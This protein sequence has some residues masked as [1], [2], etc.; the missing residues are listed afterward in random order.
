MKKCIVFL[1]LLVFFG[2]EL[3]VDVDVPFEQSSLTL[4]TYFTPDSVWSAYVTSNRHILEDGPFQPVNNARI[5]VY[6]EGTPIDTLVKTDDGLY[7]SDTGK[8]T[9]GKNY[10]LTADAPGYG[11]ISAESAL[12]LPV[13]M[14][15]ATFSEIKSEHN[16]DFRIKIRIK[17]PVEKNYYQVICEREHEYYDFVTET[18]KTIRDRM[19]LRSEDPIVQSDN[20]E[21]SNVVIFDDVLFNGKEIDFTFDATLYTGAGLAS[22]TLILRTLSE[23]YYKYV[24]T[25][26]LQRNTSGDPFAQPVNVHN[27]IQNGFGIFAGYSTNTYTESK[28]RPI[29][30]GIDPPAAKPG[31]HIIITGENFMTNPENFI[32]VY[33]KGNPHVEYATVVESSNDQL[34]VIVPANA[35]TGKIAVESGRIVIS[36]TDFQ[37]ID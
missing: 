34:E 27:N 28:P 13:Q 7:Q 30:S 17:D 37:V 25:S 8:P 9:A 4:N 22:T 12:P 23:D 5:I 26:S 14:V 31:D 3:V 10:N 11:S 20:E 35:V 19:F 24:L 1:S 15:N 18:I 33:F 29:I 21:Y 2:C 32:I 36:D 6:E 16:Q